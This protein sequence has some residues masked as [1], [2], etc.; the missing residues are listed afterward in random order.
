MLTVDKI[1][2]DVLCKNQKEE[3]ISDENEKKDK[4]ISHDEGRKVLQLVLYIKLQKESTVVDVCFKKKW[5]DCALKKQLN[6][7]KQRKTTNFCNYTFNC[8]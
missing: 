4:T 1:V 7:K 6:I 8:L 2:Q 5:C 3:E